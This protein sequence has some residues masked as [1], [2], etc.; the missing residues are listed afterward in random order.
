VLPV[1]VPA[2]LAEPTG[3]PELP[4][5]LLTLGLL[6]ASSGAVAWKVRGRHTR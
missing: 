1:A 2:G 6:L 3:S 4:L 5:V